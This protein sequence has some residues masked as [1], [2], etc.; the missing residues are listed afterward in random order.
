MNPDKKGGVIILVGQRGSGKT[1]IIK[2][3]IS[4]AKTKNIVVYDPRREYPAEYTLFHQFKYF[5]KFIY[6]IQDAFVVI[7]EAT[8]MVTQF[9]DLELSEQMIAAEHNNTILFFVFHSLIDTPPYIIRNCNYLILL[10]TGDDPEAIKN[11]RPAI[12]PYM[13]KQRPVYIKNS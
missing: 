6:N 9:K 2:K 11:S 7:E 1:P 10:N 5:K 12:Y 8:S 13:S 4:E 3:Y